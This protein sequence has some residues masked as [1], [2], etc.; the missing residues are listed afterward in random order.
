MPQKVLYVGIDESNNGNGSVDKYGEKLPTIYVAVFSFNDQDIKIEEKIQKKNNFKN[1]ES[2]L[3]KRLGISILLLDQTDFN[4]KFNHKEKPGRISVSLANKFF[5]KNEI[6]RLIE[7]VEFYFDGEYR[8]EQVKFTEKLVKDVLG[9]ESR[10]YHDAHLD[11]KMPLV[12]LADELARYLFKKRKQNESN[13]YKKFGNH[14]AY[15][16]I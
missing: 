4:Y 16:L 10:F 5:E 3:K 1:L 2:K 13:F 8:V 15:L 11:T 7:R 6:K 12:N 14:I 9:I